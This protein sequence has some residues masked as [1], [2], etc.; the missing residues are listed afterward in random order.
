M[1]K[2]LFFALIMCA[3]VSVSADYV[4]ADIITTTDGRTIDGKIVGEEGRNLRIEVTQGFVYI[5]KSTL[6]GIQPQKTLKETYAEKLSQIDVSDADAVYGLAKW[7]KENK[8]NRNC[9][10][11]LEK[12]VAANPDYEPARRAL[13]YVKYEGEWLTKDEMMIVMGY[14][15]YNDKWYP[16]EVVAEL[17]RT[18]QSKEFLKQ[19]KEENKKRE[20][21]YEKTRKETYEM[22]M[23]AR[24]SLL[25]SEQ[26]GQKNVRSAAFESSYSFDGNSGFTVKASTFSDTSMEPVRNYN[27]YNIYPTNRVVTYNSDG[28][29]ESEP[30][31]KAAARDELPRRKPANKAPQAVKNNPPKA[32]PVKAEKQAKVKDDKG[33]GNDI[34]HTD[35]DNPGQGKGNHGAKQPGGQNGNNGNNNGNVA[36]NGNGNGNSSENN[37]SA[38]GNNGNA[39]SG[40]NNGNND[41][42]ENNGN[43]NGNNGHGNNAD[44]DDGDNPGQGQGSH[45]AEPG[46]DNDGMDNDENLNNGSNGQDNNDNNNGNSNNGNDNGNANENENDNG[47]NAADNEQGNSDNNGNNGN[48][49][50]NNDNANG[51]SNSNNNGNSNGNGNSGNTKNGKK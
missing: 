27:T 19:Q 6:L 34:G 21:F 28:E 18:E 30:V 16:A 35:E 4:R 37:N 13:G 15:K 17:I 24:R 9:N 45:G 3:I 44:Q 23:K 42:N 26:P 39:N 33:H 40:N 5:P 8:L 20:K 25:Y 7:C 47:N 36:N 46:A 48:G 1:G 32:V 11:L 41:S 10:E 22:A 43:G 31:Q 14:I 2:L 12:A 38:N 49:N 51:N 29:D 50:A